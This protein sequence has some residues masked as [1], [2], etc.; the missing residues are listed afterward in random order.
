VTPFWAAVAA[1][2]IEVITVRAGAWF[3]NPSRV[4]PWLN[5]GLTA[6]VVVLVCLSH[7]SW[8]R[9][10][11]EEFAAK[12]LGGITPFLE[13]PLVAKRVAELTG[14]GDYVYVAGSEPQIL[15]YA[16]RFSPTRFIIAYP[17][18]FP[19][20]VAWRYQME[21]KKD[22]EEHP[23]KVLV[24]VRSPDSWLRQE[25][26]PL[27]F[28]MYVQRLFTEEYERVGGFT[29]DGEKGHWQEPESEFEA[30]KSSLVV[31]RRKGMAK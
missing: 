14:P 7:L 23:P 6:V 27:E 1:L 10:G 28:L 31:Y 20:P 5:G 3:R 12:R 13:S 16:N 21:A 11:R 19:S 30:A 24:V 22:L 17:M 29:F 2:G 8:M 4:E 15:Y 18:M 26:S 9:L 25:N